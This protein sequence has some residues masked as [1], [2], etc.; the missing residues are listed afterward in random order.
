MKNPKNINRV[1]RG[2]EKAGDKMLVEIP[3]I[4]IPLNILQE[5]FGI[6]KNNPMYD[7]YCIKDKEYLRL[8][9]YLED[10][11]KL[12]LYDYFLEIK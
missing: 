2:Y 6:N 8:K 4:N 12:D 7:C 5:I 3:L 9:P 10:C 1:I 11:L